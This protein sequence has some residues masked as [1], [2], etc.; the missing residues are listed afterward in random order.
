MLKN[1]LLIAFMCIVGIAIVSFF[2][3]S[4]SKCGNIGNELLQI[5]AKKRKGKVIKPSVF[6]FEFTKPILFFYH[7]DIKIS[8][9]PFGAKPA[10]GASGTMIPPAALYH[11][12]I[13]F[14]LD[15]LKGF[16]L[17]IRSKSIYTEIVKLVKFNLINI[18][19]GNPAFNEEFVIKTNNENLAYSVLTN[20]IQNK[21]LEY[22]EY[23]E[24]YYKLVKPIIKIGKGSFILTLP[25]IPKTDK[26]YDD[27]IDI[28]LMFCDRLK[29]IG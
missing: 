7:N 29:E 26:G 5:Q 12:L 11:I 10:I 25:A 28:A 16:N 14:N 15:S 3:Y 24:Y 23:S 20:N 8:L 2:I 6:S 17:F 13:K 27:V 19:V 1:V 4:I 21:L 9:F 22:S 18:Q